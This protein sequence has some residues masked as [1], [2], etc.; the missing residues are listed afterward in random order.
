MKGVLPNYFSS[1]WSFSSFHIQESHSLVCFAA[2]K[3]VI[4]GKSDSI[5]IFLKKKI[6]LFF[7][8]LFVRM[9]LSIVMHLTH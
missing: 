7:L 2:D 3:D 1:E 9:D 5:S 4:F 8:Q 6:N